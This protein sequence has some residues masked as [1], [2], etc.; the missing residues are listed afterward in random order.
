MSSAKLLGATLFLL[1]L[2]C[3]NSQ[4][5]TRLRADNNMPK[6]VIPV[7]TGWEFR[8]VGKDAWAKAVEQDKN[9]KRMI[10]ATVF[11]AS[12]QK[13]AELTKENFAFFET[14]I[15]PILAERCYECHSGTAR[16]VRGNLLLDSQAGMAKGGDNGA[17][18][19]PGNVE[20]SRL[21]QALRWTDPSFVMP[22]K[23]KLSPRQIDEWL[24]N[25]IHARPPS[26]AEMGLPLEEGEGPSPNREQV[27]VEHHH[28]AASTETA[29]GPVETPTEPAREPPPSEQTP[30]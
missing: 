3:Y 5:Q 2:T 25:A 9:S 15:R 4:S 22:P 28:A 30:A 7:E 24:K 11:D 18:L 14:Y 12:A 16:K 8:E 21:I 27:E 13:P 26:D 17:V 23:E 1:A 29:T 10:Q 6:I 19:V 20:K